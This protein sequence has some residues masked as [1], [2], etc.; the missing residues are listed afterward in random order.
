[1]HGSWK[2][3]IV[4]ILSTCTAHKISTLNYTIIMAEEGRFKCGIVNEN[5]IFETFIL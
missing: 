2:L 4:Y 1:V 3:C 5:T